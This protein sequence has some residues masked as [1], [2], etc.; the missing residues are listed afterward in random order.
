MGQNPRIPM[1]RM[2]NLNSRNDR[3]ETASESVSIAH[4]KALNDVAEPYA[5]RQGPLGKQKAKRR[6]RSSVPST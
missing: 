3:S 1:E 6:G 2:N 4:M 5:Y